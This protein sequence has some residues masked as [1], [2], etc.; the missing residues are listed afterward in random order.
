MLKRVHI[1]LL[2]SLGRML[3][4]RGRRDTLGAASRLIALELR[5][6]LIQSLLELGNSRPLGSLLDPRR[7]RWAGKAI[8]LEPMA[9]VVMQ[10]RGQIMVPYVRTESRDDVERRGK[11]EYRADELVQL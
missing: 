3:G 1:G 11:L 2:G 7:G 4:W 10:R 8:F 9:S 6:Q 5:R